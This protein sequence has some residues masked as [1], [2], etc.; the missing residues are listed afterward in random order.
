MLYYAYITIFVYHV[1][2]TVVYR[3]TIT[4]FAV[5][6]VSVVTNVIGIA[7]TT[8]NKTEADSGLTT[9]TKVAIAAVAAGGVVF[10][11]VAATAAVG[12]A[13]TSAAAG[14][15]AVGGGGT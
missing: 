12:A 2:F 6:T 9:E 7:E 13:S 3:S 8:T 11:G 10:A 1:I 15:T 14:S 4:E 5:T